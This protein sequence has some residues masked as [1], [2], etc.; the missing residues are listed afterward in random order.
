[1]DILLLKFKVTWSVSLIHWNVVLWRARKP[2]WLA[3]RRPFSSM[4]LW[5]IFRKTFSNSLSVVDNRTYIL[6]KFW[7]LTGFS[8]PSNISENRRRRQLVIK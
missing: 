8:N 3:L 4:H 2:N 5:T 7:V 1:V 6:W